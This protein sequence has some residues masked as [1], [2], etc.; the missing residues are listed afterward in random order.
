MKLI[1]TTLKLSFLV[2]IILFVLLGM[3]AYFF[4]SIIGVGIILLTKFWYVWLIFLLIGFY[5]FQKD[6]KRFYSWFKKNK[7]KEKINKFMKE[8][9]ILTA[10][11]LIIFLG[12]VTVLIVKIYVLLRTLFNT[13]F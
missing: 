3:I 4:G 2:I 12:S 6:K 10:V 11:I 13:I 5:F 9:K 8:H 7:V 1:R